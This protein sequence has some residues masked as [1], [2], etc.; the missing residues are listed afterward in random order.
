MKIIKERKRWEH[1]LHTREFELKG[2]RGNGWCFDS[3]E[4][5]NV[6]TDKLRA[7][8]PAA[9]DNYIM[10]ISGKTKAGDEIVD[11]GH[12]KTLSQGSDPAIGRCDCGLEVHLCGFTNT[13]ECGRDFNMSGQELAPR[14][15]WGQETG[16]T[17][18]DILRGGDMFDEDY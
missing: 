9:Y 13:C 14:S 11:L 18:A 10:C 6:D 8:R 16:E 5:G 12:M 2:H 4:N 1:I 3:D 15:H 7:E 17:A